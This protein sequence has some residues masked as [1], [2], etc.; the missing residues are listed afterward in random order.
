MLTSTGKSGDE[1]LSWPDLYL[2][3]SS[4]RKANSAQAKLTT[5]FPRNRIRSPMMF[6]A[7]TLRTLF[8]ISPVAF[9]AAWQKPFP[10]I[11]ICTPNQKLGHKLESRKM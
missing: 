9:A 3:V 5:T 8:T 6:T 1:T 11:A 10:L 7:A 2:W 4:I